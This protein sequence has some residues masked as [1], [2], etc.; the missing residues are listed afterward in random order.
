MADWAVEL[1]RDNESLKIELRESLDALEG[2]FQQYC[3]VNEKT[4]D[5][6]DMYDH[7]CMSAGEDAA[8]VLLKHKR[9]TMTQ[10]VRP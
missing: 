1:R 8:D 6:S 3:R 2:M 5:G 10:L 7:F 4:L 9:I